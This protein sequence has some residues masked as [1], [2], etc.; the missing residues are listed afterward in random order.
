MLRPDHSSPGGGVRAAILAT[1]ALLLFV[2]PACGDWDGGATPYTDLS[3]V[4][5]HVPSGQDRA[6]RRVSGN[7][8]T[9]SAAMNRTSNGPI[10][11]IGQIRG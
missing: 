7:G 10:L 9:A 5:R 2:L 3:A 11:R 4:G 1:L 6:L 8:V